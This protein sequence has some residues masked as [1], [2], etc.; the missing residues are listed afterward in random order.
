MKITIPMP[1]LVSIDDV[2]WWKGTDGSGVNQPFRT[3]MPRDHV[4]EDYLALADLGRC[5]DM[6]LLAGFV[7][8][9]WDR[10]HILQ[11]LP[12][13]TWMGKNWT[14]PGVDVEQKIK[15]AEIIQNS[16]KY[17]EFGLHGLGHE[18]WDQGVMQ[19]SEFHD[20]GCRMR[21][22]DEIRKHLSFFCKI[23]DQYGFDPRPK[24]FIPP[25]LKHSF[26]DPDQ[27]IQKILAEFGIESVTLMFSKAR[28]F[29]SPQAGKMAWENDVL[30][31]DRG[32]SEIPW[33]RVA[34]GPEFKFDRPVMALHWANL[35][36][37]DPEQNLSVIQKWA[38]YI[39]TGSAKRGMLL[40]QDSGSCFTQYAHYLMSEIKQTD[41]GF[42]IDLGWMDQVP[43]RLSKNPVYLKVD[44]PPGTDLDIYGAEPQPCLRPAEYPFLKL[45]LPDRSRRI[46]IRPR[47]LP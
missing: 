5:L 4:P 13:S 8:C 31:V 11:N 40:V 27:G 15:A 28:L 43:P 33:N 20:A 38:D 19:R 30:L 16:E 46:F 47:S 44:M 3:G 12:S 10:G 1:L 39:K 9:E 29:S 45:V 7:L 34:A 17:I 42:S 21:D 36:H 14:T 35:L 6:R 32:E 18:F 23:M 2:G 22:P 41:G 24:T 37:P 25:A 26:G